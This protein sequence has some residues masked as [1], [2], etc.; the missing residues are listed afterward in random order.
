MWATLAITLSGNNNDYSPTGFV[1]VDDD[2]PGAGT[3]ELDC[4]GADRTITGFAAGYKGR[5]LRIVNVSSGSFKVILPDSSASSAVGNKFSFAA[6]ATVNILKGETFVLVY[7]GAAGAG[8]WRALTSPLP[9]ASGGSVSDAAFPTGWDADTTGAASRNALYDYLH[10]SDT[11][12]DGKVNVLNT[13]AGIVKTNSGGV[14]STATA[15]TDYILD[16]EWQS[17][18]AALGSAIKANSLGGNALN[19][20]TSAALADGT[21]RIAAVYL[22]KGG[23]ITGISFFQSVQGSYTADNNNYLAL[24]SFTPGASNQL[25]Q[26]AITANDGTVWKATSNSLVLVP[27]SVTGTPTPYTAAAGLYFVAA[28][29]NSSAQTTAP[30]LGAYTSSLALGITALDFQNSGKTSATLASQTALTTPLTMS[31]LTAVPAIPWFG[32]YT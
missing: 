22:Q 21:A 8:T 19:A 32:L 14:V 26:V 5:V 16:F 11:D 25:N 9:G 6:A 10:I 18:F 20:S 13:G 28:L 4:S 17:A 27:F 15:G 30:S 1:Y 2:H 31:G 24:Y 7:S 29:Y 12:D 3:L 23:S